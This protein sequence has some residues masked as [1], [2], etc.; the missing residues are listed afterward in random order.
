[1]WEAARAR[2]DA[3]GGE[4]GGSATEEEKL[5]SDGS[6]G[7]KAGKPERV[8]STKRSGARRAGKA[9][10]GPKGQKQ[11]PAEKD[12]GIIEGMLGPT[13]VEGGTTTGGSAVSNAKYFCCRAM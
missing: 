7:P 3:L 10:D 4:S 8:R 9:A 6:G 12:A 11:T 2:L 5:Q 1:M 13:A